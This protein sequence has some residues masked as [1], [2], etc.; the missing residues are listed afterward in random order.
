MGARQKLNQAFVTGSLVVAAFIGIIADSWLVFLVALAVLI[1]SNLYGQDIRPGR[2][3][4]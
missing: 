3:N 2:R 1:G 4:R